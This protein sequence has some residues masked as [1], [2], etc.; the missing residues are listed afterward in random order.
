[1]I[2][3]KTSRLRILLL[4]IFTAGL[5]ATTALFGITY[6]K[7]FAAGVFSDWQ[8]GGWTIGEEDGEAVL[9]GSPSAN[10]NVLY[11]NEKISAAGLSFDIYIDTVSGENGNIGAAYKCTSGYQYF[12]E[13]SV[14][15]KSLSVKR[16]SE[17]GGES[18]VSDRVSYTLSSKKWYSMKMTLNTISSS[19]RSLPFRH[20]PQPTVM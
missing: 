12:F 4:A 11:S 18:V 9:F 6:T 14:A 7:T 10:L 2:N 5:V 16:I 3:N 1:M 19:K 13:Y 17:R 15:N 20:F 8:T